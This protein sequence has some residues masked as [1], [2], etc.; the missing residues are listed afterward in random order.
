[1]NQTQ[2]TT[3]Y[4]AALPTMSLG[5]ISLSGVLCYPASGPD[6][7]FEQN[8][9]ATI[10]TLQRDL[11]RCRNECRDLIAERDEA[12]RMRE[13][14]NR[15]ISIARH[16][17]YPE[18]EDDRIRPALVLEKAIAAAIDAWVDGNAVTIQLCPEEVQQWVALVV[19]HGADVTAFALDEMSDLE[20]GP[21]EVWMSSN[22]LAA[23][24]Q[25]RSRVIGFSAEKP[26]DEP[27]DEGPATITN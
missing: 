8:A 25:A 3:D 5:R 10:N 6:P 7:F 13:W 21:E 2:I 12:V 18:Q 14:D 23:L 4:T 11:D 17:G 15:A 26:A 22:V 19:T 1:M 24:D 9:A 27:A 20:Q 16:F